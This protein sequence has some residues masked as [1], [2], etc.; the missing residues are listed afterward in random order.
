VQVNVYRG[1]D[2]ALADINARYGPDRIC[3]D[4]REPPGPPDLDGPVRRLAK[5]KGWRDGVWDTRAPD[6]VL[7]IVADRSAAHA[8]W[9]ANV[10][11]DLP[12]EPQDPAG[13]GVFATLADVDFDREAVVVWSA[14]Q[15]PGCPEWLADITTDADGRCTSTPNPS[16]ARRGAST[17]DA[18]TAWSSR[19]TGT[20]CHSS[21]HCPPRPPGPRDARVTVYS[22]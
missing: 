17:W 4:L 19:S 22:P 3:L 7:E 6:A 8:A 13:V 21:A 18:P 16:Q 20:A 11:D 9:T 5:A 10:P 15:S 2:E 12:R 14:T 1:D